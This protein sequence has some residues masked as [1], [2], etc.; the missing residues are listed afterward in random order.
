MAR[1]RNFDS[2]FYVIGSSNCFFGQYNAG[3]LSFVNGNN[4][5]ETADSA[6][7]L[8]KDGTSSHVIA[9]YDGGFRV[10]DRLI[11]ANRFGIVDLQPQLDST[12]EVPI[13]EL[14]LEKLPPE[15][16]VKSAD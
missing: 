15:P 4:P 10:I 9:F 8:S 7:S 12:K 16:V 2:P 6:L 13:Y 5:Y 14:H 1:F 3:Q 11:E